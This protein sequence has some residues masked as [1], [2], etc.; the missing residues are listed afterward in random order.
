MNHGA[1]QYV[2]GIAYTNT[3]ESFWS[4]L[5]RGIVGQYHHVTA[6]HL[7]AYIDEFC[8]RYNHRGNEEIFE[9]FIQ[10]SVI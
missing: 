8:F 5:K 6:Q 10:K 2:V 7:D 9:L 3:I 1:G 4:L